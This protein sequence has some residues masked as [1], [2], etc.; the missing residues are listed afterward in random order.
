MALVDC[1]QAQPG[2]PSIRPA[3]DRMQGRRVI[4]CCDPLLSAGRDPAALDDQPRRIA[5]DIDLTATD[6]IA[7][8]ALRRE[9]KEGELD[10]GRASIKD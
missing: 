2:K 1:L 5:D 9:V 3:S 6:P 10:A 4:R 8:P 7:E